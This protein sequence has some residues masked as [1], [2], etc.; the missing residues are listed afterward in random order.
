MSDT[1]VE[2]AVNCAIRHIGIGTYSSGKIYSYLSGKNYSDSVCSEA[3]KLLVESGYINDMR[4]ARKVLL[5]R[6]GMKQESRAYSYKRL[7]CAGKASHSAEEYLSSIEN[8]E[9]TCKSLMSAY[10]TIADSPDEEGF[11]KLAKIRGYTPEVA[12]RTWRLND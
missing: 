1:V 6:T 3:V 12:C 4:A 8:D 9:T 11:I 2:Q 10:F 7:M 5:L